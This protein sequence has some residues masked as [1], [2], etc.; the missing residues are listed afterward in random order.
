MAS[1][2]TV[3]LRTI[4]QMVEEEGG[5]FIVDDVWARMP[6]DIDV[7]DRRQMGCA[8]RA[9]KDKGWILPT[10][11]YRMSGQPQCHQNPRQVWRAA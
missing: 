1:F 10:G 9:A 3:A 4:K 5:T 7:D 2:Q 8:I 6:D 11:T